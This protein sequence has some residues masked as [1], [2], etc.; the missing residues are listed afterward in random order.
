MS[1]ITNM[2]EASIAGGG[3]P[4]PALLPRGNVSVLPE[5]ASVPLAPPVLAPV[6][7]PEEVVDPEPLEAPDI[8]PVSPDVAI[9][10]PDT[11]EPELTVPPELTE[12]VVA[13][14]VPEAG[15]LVP[16]ETDPE[17]EPPPPAEP[18]VGFCDE[19]L[20]ATLVPPPGDDEQAAARATKADNTIARCRP[21]P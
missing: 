6:A 21:R 20:D 1:C 11:A 18:V 7:A 16:E 4:Q 15:E 2:P 9:P 12:P 19:P 3:L 5:A 13:P 10:V 8:V 17:L 14:A